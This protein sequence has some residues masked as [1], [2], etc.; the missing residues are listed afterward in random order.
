[1]KINQTKLLPQVL[2]KIK[3]VNDEAGYRTYLEVPEMI[4]IICEC[5]EATCN[6][7]YYLFAA[8]IYYARG[9][10]NDFVESSTS[11][12]KLQQLAKQKFSDE[13]D[14][15]QWYHICDENMNIVD[16]SEEQAYGN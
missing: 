6:K 11:F 9:G 14:Y 2:E 7:R 1:M 8:N 15:V 5:I 3:E 4:R 12:E 10:V 13:E 16:K